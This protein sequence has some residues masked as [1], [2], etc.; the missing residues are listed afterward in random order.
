MMLHPQPPCHNLLDIDIAC[1]RRELCKMMLPLEHSYYN[2]QDTGIDCHRRALSKTMLH[3][4]HSFHN[5]QDTGIACH[6]CVFCTTP[7]VA[8]SI[9]THQPCMVCDI[10]SVSPCATPHGR[11]VGP[12]RCSGFCCGRHR[13]IVS[14][15]PAFRQP[16]NAFPLWLSSFQVQ[17]ISVCLLAV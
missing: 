13:A 1:H 16:G 6:C 2:L 10:A 3:Q 17:M 14:L 15:P 11:V 7:C 12:R 5:H 9:Y 4:L 8:H